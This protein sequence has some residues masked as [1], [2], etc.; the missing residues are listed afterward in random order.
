MGRHWTEDRVEHAVAAFSLAHGMRG[1]EA[2]RAGGPTLVNHVG[3]DAVASGRD[4]QLVYF[5]VKAAAAR[6]QDVS[7]P[8]GT[9]PGRFRID[10]QQ[11]PQLYGT[12]R[13]WFVL[14]TYDFDDPV[15]GQVVWLQ[16]VRSDQLPQRATVI[17]LSA[18]RAGSGG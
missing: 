1:F 7:K 14:C 18:C 5:D 6:V 11:Y 3:A 13:L 17:S 15:T 16:I 10:P 2:N 8:N 9:R 4:G 12:R